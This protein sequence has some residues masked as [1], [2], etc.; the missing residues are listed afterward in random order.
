M[1]PGLVRHRTAP[2]ECPS[3]DA[4][5]PEF[6]APVAALLWFGNNDGG[7]ADNL[8]VRLRLQMAD[9][10][11]RIERT[12][13]SFSTIYLGGI[14]PMITDASAFLSFVCILTATEALAG[15]RFSAKESN[16]GERFNEFVR[17]YFPPEYHPFTQPDTAYRDGRLWFFRCRLIHGFSPAG[18]SLIHHHSEVHLRLN[19]DTGGPVLNAEDFYAALLFAAQRYF[20]DLRAESDL[21]AAFIVRLEDKD[22]GGTIAVG[23]VRLKL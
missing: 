2:A 21:Q 8:R 20:D 15:Y 10:D 23:P 1:L 9:I 11:P 12:I 18:F 5:G 7:P 17:T 22:R 19:R 4:S 13:K 3:A 14:P 16:P 6:R